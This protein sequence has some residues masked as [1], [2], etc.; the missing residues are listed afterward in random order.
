VVGAFGDNLTATAQRLGAALALD[1]EPLVRL[2][3]LGECLNYNAYGDTQADLFVPTAEVYRRMQAYADPLQFIDAEPVLRTIRKGYE[4]DLA[5]ARR[6]LPHQPCAGGLVWLLPHAA[7]SR[8]VR[9]V[10]ANT[11][12]QQHPDLAHAVVA[13]DGAGGHAVSVRAP[14]TRPRGAAELCM[15]FPGGGGRCGAA[16]IDH[17]PDAQLQDFVKAFGRAFGAAGHSGA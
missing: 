3:E 1:P 13:A 4:S 15:A 8:R 11:V 5:Q 12:V 2:Q 16:G 9:G 10:F 17:L 7:W 14:R 6:I